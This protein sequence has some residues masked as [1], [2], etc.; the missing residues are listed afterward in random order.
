MIWVILD[1]EVCDF[2]WFV[3]EDMCDFGCKRTFSRLFCLFLFCFLR[4]C[5]IKIPIQNDELMKVM[6]W[7]LKLV[8]RNLFRCLIFLFNLFYFVL[9][10]RPPARSIWHPRLTR[11]RCLG[12]SL[13]LL[14]VPKMAWP[15]HLHDEQRCAV[16]FRLQ[17]QVSGIQM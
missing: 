4:D 10:T 17:V 11:M 9:E 15:L 5:V 13:L 16:P 14:T 12:P 3:S 2:E 8:L 6:N 1:P 7:F